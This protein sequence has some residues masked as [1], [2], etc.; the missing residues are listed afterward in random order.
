M[1]SRRQDAWEAQLKEKAFLVASIKPI[2]DDTITFKPPVPYALREVKRS[3]DKGV[4]FK[5]NTYGPAGTS[6]VS[7]ATT[8]YEY[9]SW[10]QWAQTPARN[11]AER[12]EGLSNYVKSFTWNSYISEF[13]TQD[14]RNDGRAQ[15]TAALAL[16]HMETFAEL[17][18]LRRETMMTTTAGYAALKQP[19]GRGGAGAGAA[20]RAEKPEKMVAEMQTLELVDELKLARMV[21]T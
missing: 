9:D 6:G 18:K 7:H 11:I 19:G 1:A 2:V 12:N 17:D 4:Y 13:G 5:D 14:E 20:M 8:M 21:M 16:I 15:E 10:D 3:M